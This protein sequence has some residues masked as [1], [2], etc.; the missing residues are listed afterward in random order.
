MTMWKVWFAI[1][2]QMMLMLAMISA[3]DDGDY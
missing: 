2:S 1:I 3:L